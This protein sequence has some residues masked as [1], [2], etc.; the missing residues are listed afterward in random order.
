MNATFAIIISCFMTFGISI[1]AISLGYSGDYILGEF[2][3]SGA[4]AFMKPWTFIT[5]IFL[6]FDISHLLSNMLV[7][8]F[9]GTSVENELGK[10]RMLL[11][12]FAGALMGNIFSFFYYP[13]EVVSLGASAGVFALIGAGMLIKPLDMSFYP[14]MVP[15]PLGII[16]ILYAIYNSIG[17]ASGAGN[18]SFIAHFGG[19]LV[20]LAV[21]F[22]HEGFWK[23]I[24]TMTLSILALVIIIMLLPFAYSI[25]F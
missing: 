23:G 19:L 17:F 7:L 9:F 1:A 24:S 22:R 20:G 12:F 13:P 4:S 5:C 10:G 15:V 21:G 14:F 11:I 18:I 25:L 6:H 8:L 16:G 3:F 2:G